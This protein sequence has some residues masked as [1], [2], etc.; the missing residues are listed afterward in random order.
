MMTMRRIVLIQPAIWTLTLVA[1]VVFADAGTVTLPGVSG[2]TFTVNKVTSL[3]EARYRSTIHQQYDFSCGSAALAT[4]LTYH[5]Q[6]TVTEPEVFKWMYDHGNQEKIRREG[7]SLLDMKNYLEAHGYTAD[8][9]YASLDKLA[10]AGVPAITL[11][12]IKNYR[13]FVVVKGVTDKKVLV[14][15]PSAGVKIMPRDEFEQMWNGLVFIIRNKN[16]LSEDNFNRMAEWRGVKGKAPLGTALI[17]T[18]LANITM[19]LPGP[20]GAGP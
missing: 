20:G 6:D 12:N 1:S 7:F 13:H 11:I 19:L 16:I 15:D 2:G 18:D 17:T 5:Y 4:L 9:Y 8:G 3:K 14:G 10:E